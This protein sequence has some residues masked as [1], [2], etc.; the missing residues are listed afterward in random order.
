MAEKTVLLDEQT[1]ARVLDRL[2]T[3]EGEAFLARLELTGPDLVEALTTVYGDRT[4]VSSLIAALVEDALTAA[5][6]RPLPLRVLDRRREVDQTWFLREDMVGY[7]CYADRFAGGLRGVAEHLDYLAE[8]GVS[9]L[10]LM[11]L[12]KPREGESDG[13]YAVEDY[14]AVDPR[15]GTMA[16]LEALSAALH[17]RG[18]ALCVD[19]VLNHTAR[20][21]LWAQKALAGDPAYRDFYLLFPDRTLPDAYERTLPDVFPGMAP[22]SFTQV[23]ETGEWVWTTFHEFQWDL[24]WA[25]PEVFRAMLGVLY[26]L[27]NHGVDVVRLDAAP[28]LW[29]RLGTDC[30]NQPEAHRILQALR[31]LSRLAMPGLALKAEAIVGPDQLVPY[32]GGHDHYRPEC[33]LAYDNQLM[34]MI[35]SAL[36]TRDVRLP[37]HA[38]G[39]RRQPP[40]QT[41]WVTYVRCHDDIGWAV[42]DEDAWA[43]G[44]N[45]YEHRRFL[46]AYY[47]GRHPGSFAQGA[48]FQVDPST[49]DSRTSGM[50]ASLVGLEQ[51]LASGS[52]A[53]LDAA[54]DRMETMYA[55]AYS[56]GGIPLIYSGDELALRNDPAW[57]ADPEH[58]DDNRWLHRPPMDWSTAER[59]HQPGTPEGRMFTALRTLGE[60][61]RTTPALR[62]DADTWVVSQPNARVL[63]F[64]RSHPRGA[65]LLVVACFSDTEE[66][67]PDSVLSH[68]GIT[69]PVHVHSTSGQLEWSRGALRLAPWSFAWVTD[70]R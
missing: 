47:A 8:L 31:A 15:L 23:P 45:P 21:H 42:S 6:E 65:P 4:D 27:A 32:L 9:Y 46:A 57:A 56:F 12:L 39:R 10:H 58:A 7:V 25:N 54:L 37:A 38:L 44:L 50:A 60:V 41:G 51:A 13:G 24:N 55:V 70:S 11:P 66:L 49:G 30:Q 62:S 33:D 18:T 34:V 63:A 64:A 5:V 16:D 3:L 14:D 22:G 35:W 29:K 36:A 26:T 59:R 20:E 52:A 68:A 43:T 2:G 40:R 61:R 1:V 48:D 53:E 67:V 19:L 28:F 17:E 69:S